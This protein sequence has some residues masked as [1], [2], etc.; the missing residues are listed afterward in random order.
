MKRDTAPPDLET[1]TVQGFLLKPLPPDGTKQWREWEHRCKTLPQKA[2]DLFVEALKRGTPSEQEVAL[3]A[4][5]Y[6]GFESWQAGDRE[7]IRYIY[8][9]QGDREWNVIRPMLKLN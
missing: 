4:L 9:R 7:D 8:R 6:H 3:I 2:A 1:L 5:R